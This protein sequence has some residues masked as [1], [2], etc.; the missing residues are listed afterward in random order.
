MKTTTYLKFWLA[1]ILMTTSY[2]LQEWGM[3]LCGDVMDDVHQVCVA[4]EATHEARPT[5]H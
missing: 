3:K 4:K 5:L 2:R 1:N